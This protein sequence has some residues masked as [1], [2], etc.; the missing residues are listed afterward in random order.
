MAKEGLAVGADGR[1]IHLCG[2]ERHQWC[3]RRGRDQP[4]L[5]VLERDSPSPP[6]CPPTPGALDTVTLGGLEWA[7][8]VPEC[9]RGRGGDRRRVGDPLP[10]SGTPAVPAVPRGLSPGLLE[11]LCGMGGRTPLGQ[12]GLQENRTGVTVA[13][14]LW[15]PV[16]LDRNCWTLLPSPALSPGMCSIPSLLQLPSLVPFLPNLE[17]LGCVFWGCR[18]FPTPASP[19]L[20]S[21]ISF[22]AG[23]SPRTFP[24]APPHR[25]GNPQ[26]CCQRGRERAA[27]SPR[28]Q[29]EPSGGPEP[30]CHLRGIAAAVPRARGRHGE[31][32]ERGLSAPGGRQGQALGWVPGLGALWILIFACS[33]RPVRTQ[34]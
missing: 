8:P 23:P 17:P 26:P 13:G 31:G 16:W 29:K 24:E 2:R 28:M 30:S 34:D 25:A 5:P 10:S 9:G 33:T 15:C 3:L 7:S 27:A 32:G 4:G 19:P 14:S 21:P 1:I 18:A 20:P 22:P 11:G 12:P 6:Q